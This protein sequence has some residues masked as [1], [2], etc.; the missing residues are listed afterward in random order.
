MKKGFFIVIEGAD[1][2]G[3]STQAALLGEFL[4]RRDFDVV[5]T[6]EPTDGL[7]GQMI[8]KVLA[9]EL[10]VSPRALALLFTADRAEHVEN[11]IQP[12]L[13]QGKVV[14]S[15][16][17]YYS[18]VVYQSAQGVEREWLSQMNS[19]V[20][21]PDLVIV[22]DFPPAD[23]ADRIKD[24]QKE[25]F[26]VLKIQERIYEKFRKEVYKLHRSLKKPGKSWR[27]IYVMPK[28]DEQAVHRKIRTEVVN[29]KLMNGNGH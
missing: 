23:A 28:D 12:A 3:K 6:R 27:V 22:L 4:K 13:D 1:G 10:K 5:V 19:F 16:R 7:I 11:V 15:D 29:S 9:G 20:P 18:T 17:Y 8:R 26:E 14:I 24:R 25:V 21:E 2:T